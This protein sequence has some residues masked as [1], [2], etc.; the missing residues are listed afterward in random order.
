M[1]PSVNKICGIIDFDGFNVRGEFLV[2]EF[3]YISMKPTWRKGKS[4][5]YDLRPYSYLIT[6]KDSRCIHYVVNNIFGMPF[7]PFLGEYVHKLE[8][9]DYHVVDFYESC[10]SSYRNILGYK[11]GQIEKEWLDGLGIPSVNLE[12]YGCPK[13]NDLHCEK[14]DKISCGYHIKNLHCPR[15]EVTAFRDWIY[16]TYLS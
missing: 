16:Q 8:N 4:K 7:R 3:G 15:A 11:G 6:K 14:Y 5:R 13:F 12:I 1:S 10:R 2:R 9:L